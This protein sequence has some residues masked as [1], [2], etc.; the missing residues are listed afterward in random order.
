MK[1]SK[2]I[3]KE[4]SSHRRW[5]E[6][7]IRIKKEN[8]NKIRIAQMSMY[9]RQRVKFKD[10]DGKVTIGVVTQIEGNDYVFIDGPIR[11]HQI[12]L[13]HIIELVKF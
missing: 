5:E 7:K 13:H 2:M 11:Y 6:A 10:L 3:K 8:E 12:P 1:K 4:K 9:S